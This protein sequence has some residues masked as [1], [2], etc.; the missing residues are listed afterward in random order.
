MV[1][2]FGWPRYGYCYSYGGFGY[3]YSAYAYGSTYTFMAGSVGLNS[4]VAYTSES[5]TSA[6]P[7]KSY[8]NDYW[9][10]GRDWGQDLRRDVVT[11]DQFIAF[12]AQRI[13]GAPEAFQQRFRE[14]FQVG[15]GQHADEAF[16]KAMD[17]ARQGNST[18][19]ASRN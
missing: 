15:Y 3:P 1:V 4:T 2:Y 12:V 17:I 11:F 8:E 5:Q 13:A 19:S 18:A 16:L 14:G 10:R 7:E 9:Q 6:Q